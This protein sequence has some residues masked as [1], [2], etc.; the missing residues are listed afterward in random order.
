MS[1]GLLI[2]SFA[3]D[4]FAH[5]QCRQ[6]VGKRVDAGAIVGSCVSIR[7][8]DVESRVDVRDDEVM[9]GGMG[10]GECGEVVRMRDLFQTICQLVS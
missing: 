4:F 7:P 6:T 1:G 3:K 5:D 10:Q 9:E 2:G 8:D